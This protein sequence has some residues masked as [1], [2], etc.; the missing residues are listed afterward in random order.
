MNNGDYSICLNMIVK[1]EA[2]VIK[3]TLENICQYLKL[4]YYV[5]SDTGS[6]DDTINIIKQFFDVK[7]VIPVV[8]KI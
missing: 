4:S 2:H 1:N 7:N 3:N 5:I 6:T 8:F